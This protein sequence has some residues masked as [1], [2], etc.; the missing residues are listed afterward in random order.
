[1]TSLG[2]AQEKCGVARN[3][4]FKEGDL[5]ELMARAVS[6][7]PE[8]QVT[9][10]VLYAEGDGMTKNPL[11]AVRLWKLAAEQKYAPAYYHLG[12]AYSEGLG[13]A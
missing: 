6:R 3:F 1:M 13:V 11:E 7:D 8:A 9:L 4:E 2:H 10:G 12:N 5:D